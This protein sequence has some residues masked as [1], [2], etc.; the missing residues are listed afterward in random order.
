MQRKHILNYLEIF[1]QFQKLLII[2]ACFV[3]L[4]Q[5]DQVLI[6]FCGLSLQV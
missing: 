6:S 4:D 1:Q 3:S 5:H 2:F